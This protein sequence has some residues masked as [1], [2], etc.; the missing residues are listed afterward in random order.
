M[1]KFKTI[2]PNDIP[3][4]EK[5]KLAIERLKKDAQVFSGYNMECRKSE[6]EAFLEVADFL[7]SFF[8]K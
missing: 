6:I 2:N 5:I 4:P 7:E 3:N 8:V 1:S